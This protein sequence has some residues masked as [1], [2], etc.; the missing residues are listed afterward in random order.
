MNP[1]GGTAVEFTEIVAGVLEVGPAEVVGTAGPAT[2]LTWTSLR[3]LE[4]VV[5]LEQAYGVSFTYQ[6]IRN[7][8]SIGQVRDVLRA[9]GAPV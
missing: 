7:L 2:L 9:K 4:L 5:T 6:D 3:H 1:Q 8:R